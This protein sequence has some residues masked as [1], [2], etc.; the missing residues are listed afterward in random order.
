MKCQIGG[1]KMISEE[2]INW[3]APGVQEIC[4]KYNLF[5]SVCIAQAAL[6]SGWGR[7]TIGKYNLFGRKAVDGDKSILVTT[8]ECYDGEWQNIS[9]AFKDYDSLEDAIEDYCVLLTEEPVYAS[10][11]EQTTVEDFVNTLGP[12]YATDPEYANKI[13]QTIGASE[14]QEY[15]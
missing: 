4:K 5:S 14:L 6:E 15:D 12:I 9:A 7:Y 8:Q 13:L 3:I 1:I 2:F 10:C 11:L